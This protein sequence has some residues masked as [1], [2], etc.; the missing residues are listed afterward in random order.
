[1]NI[2]SRSELEGTALLLFNELG[3]GFRPCEVV[4]ILSELTKLQSLAML[5]GER[6]GGEA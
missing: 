1:M 5:R 2:K 3:H 6:D 4:Y